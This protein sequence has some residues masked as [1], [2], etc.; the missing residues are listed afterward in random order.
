MEKRL[1]RHNDYYVITIRIIYRYTW[2]FANGILGKIERRMWELDISDKDFER[3]V[4]YRE[5]EASI[6]G[7]K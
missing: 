2:R 1:K 3:N 5:V 4:R 7:I 6:K